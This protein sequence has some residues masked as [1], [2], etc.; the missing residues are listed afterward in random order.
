MKRTIKFTAQRG[1]L[2]TVITV[3]HTEE[4]ACMPDTEKQV[5]QIKN[6]LYDFLRKR[7][8]NFSD[9]KENK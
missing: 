4:N 2:K 3:N 6:E 8:Y 7:N 9:I 1:D 5:E